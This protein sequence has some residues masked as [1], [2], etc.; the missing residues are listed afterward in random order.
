MAPNAE[1]RP[2]LQS[3]FLYVISVRYSHTYDNHNEVKLRAV[4]EGI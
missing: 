4:Y 1:L 2:K 3:G